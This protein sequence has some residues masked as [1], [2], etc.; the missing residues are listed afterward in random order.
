MNQK[1][2]TRPRAG[3]SLIE[4]LV[5]LAVISVLL[6]LILP[7]VQQA[8]ESARAIEC[9]NNLKQIGVAITGFEV[10]RKFLPPSRNYDHYTSW[11]FL[12][13]PHMEQVNLFESWDP[14]VKYYYQTDEARLTGISSYTCPSRR[15]AGGNSTAG[16][17]ILSPLES[18][19]HVPGTLSDYAC[20]A[21]FGRGWN[22]INSRG[23]MIIGKAQTDPPTIPFGN[24]APPNAKLVNWEGRTSMRSLSDGASHTILVGEKHVRPDRFGIAQED[25]A[26][27]NGDHPG[28]FSRPGGP[29]YPIARFPTDNFNN[30]FGSYHPGR[31]HFV[32][33]DGS[34]RGISPLISTDVLGRLTTRNDNV[35][36][37]ATDW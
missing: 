8:R 12:I 36:I 11:A 35:P 23:A 5:A 16:D 6:A 13:L 31:C 22:W 27:Y 17:D 3:F 18:S 19:P 29:G 33:A 14:A 21:G 1:L 34:V 10:Q 15:G 26:I 32:L 24:F 20:A 7:A 4:L 25:G 9:K 37:S 30:N 2:P 28:N